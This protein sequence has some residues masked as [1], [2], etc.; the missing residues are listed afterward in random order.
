MRHVLTYPQS[1]DI[2]SNNLNHKKYEEIEINSISFLQK[3]YLR[4]QYYRRGQDSKD[5]F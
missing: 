5:F 1:E 2:Q 4:N 3:L